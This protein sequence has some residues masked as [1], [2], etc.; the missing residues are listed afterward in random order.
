MVGERARP[1]RQAHGA[2]RP[3]AGLS[4]WAAAERPRERL[5]DE[6]PAALATRELLAILVGSGPA[7]RTS[8][9][10]ASRLLAD[11]GGS[12]RAMARRPVADLQGVVGVGPAVSARIAAALELGRRLASEPET[13][14]RR[15]HRP[16]DIHAMCGP[17]LRDLPHEEF[18]VVLLD[19][20]HAVLR[21]LQVSRGILDASLVHPREVFRQAIAEG[22]AA[23]ILVHNH[24]SGDVTPSAEDRAVTGQLARS[25]RI[26]G[27]P[28]LD[29][30]I[31][32]SGRWAS[33]AE[34]GALDGQV[35]R[36]PGPG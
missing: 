28:V 9:D 10:V 13:P 33:M 29:H 24:P 31:I 32:G 12:L 21:E 5:H 2:V 20:Q 18:W 25:G 6:T 14:R 30:V 3:R 19:S 16:A 7:G 27:I 36:R 35:E 1:S 15:I 4:A 34:A 8:V 23:V 26:L 11:C 17:R 22:A